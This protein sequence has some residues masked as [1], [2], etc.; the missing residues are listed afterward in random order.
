MLQLTQEQ[1][2]DEARSLRHAV[3]SPIGNSPPGMLTG[4]LCSA[5]NVNSRA[6]YKL[7]NMVSLQVFGQILAVQSSKTP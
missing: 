6:V 2:L 1:E 3:G 4:Y 7:M 5:Y